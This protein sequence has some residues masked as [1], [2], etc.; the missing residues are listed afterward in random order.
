MI[1]VRELL[2]EER[3]GWCGRGRV[4]RFKLKSLFFMV[5]AAGR[6]WWYLS[7]EEMRGWR[8][9][10]GRLYCMVGWSFLIFLGLVREEGVRGISY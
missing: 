9:F 8:F 5:R 6:V 2:L 10:V 4:L 1:G 3:W 7:R